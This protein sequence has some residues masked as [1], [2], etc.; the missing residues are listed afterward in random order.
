MPRCWPAS[1]SKG[2]GKAI[3]ASSRSASRAESYLA[4]TRRLIGEEAAKGTRIVPPTVTVTDRLEV[5]LGARKLLIEAWPTA[6]TSTDLTVYDAATGTWFL[7]DLLFAGHVPAL[8]GKL[9]GWIALLAELKRRPALRVVPGHGPASMAWPEAAAP[10]KHYL[11]RLASDVRG[12]IRDGRTLSEAA[13]AAG[14]SRA[15]KWAL[16]DDFNAR[17]ATSAF[18]EFEWE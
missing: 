6:H 14:R 5:D 3:P 18:H 13:R 2:A 12:M 15:G 7:G 11:D 10:M 17:N 1:A 9:K 16:F 4:A 8:D